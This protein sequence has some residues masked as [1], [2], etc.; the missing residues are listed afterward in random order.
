MTDLENS[1]DDLLWELHK[2]PNQ[3]A[4]DCVLLNAYFEDVE[5]LSSLLEKQV[6]IVL[7]RTLNTVRKEPTIIVTALR[8]VE[9]QEMQDEFAAQVMFYQCYILWLE[10]IMLM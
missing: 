4:A 2:S 3:S 7:G 5:E 1:R 10:C 6:R 9:W 8:I